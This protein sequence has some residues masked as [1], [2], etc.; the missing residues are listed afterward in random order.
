MTLPVETI[1]GRVTIAEEAIKPGTYFPP[2]IFEEVFG[3]D[4]KS[5]EYGLLLRALVQ[6]TKRFYN[7]SWI[8]IRQRDYGVEVLDADNASEYHANTFEKCIRVMEYANHKASLIDPKQ[9]S[10]ASRSQHERQRQ[11]MA[12]VLSA[13]DKALR[14]V[15]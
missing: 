12:L 11:K 5:H 1:S 14:H 3:C 15:K 9:L 6:D 4:R 10:D 13:Q 2:E 7:D 8:T